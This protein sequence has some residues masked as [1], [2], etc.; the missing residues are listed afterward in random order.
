MKTSVCLHSCSFQL[1]HRHEPNSAIRFPT[2][3]SCSS[4]FNRKY[5]PPNEIMEPVTKPGYRFHDFIIRLMNSVPPFTFLFFAYKTFS[6]AA[7]CMMH[8]SWGFLCACNTRNCGFPFLPNSHSWKEFSSKNMGYKI[9]ELGV[10][11]EEAAR[12]PSWV[13]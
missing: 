2:P 8:V 12:N 4:D 9:Q 6:S 10:A 11:P 5:S 3:N 13:G 1:Q 7:N